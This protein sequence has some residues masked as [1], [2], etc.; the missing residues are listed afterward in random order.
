[1]AAAANRLVTISL[2]AVVLA[3]CGGDGGDRDEPTPPAES[4][5]ASVEPVDVFEDFPVT[6]QD[7]AQLTVAAWAAPDPIRFAELTTADVHGQIIDLPGPPNPDWTFIRCAEDGDGSACSFY[8]ADGDELVL[9]VDHALLGGPR[10]T[11]AARFE[12]TGYPEDVVAYLEAFVTAWQAGNLARMHNLAVAAAV[13]VFVELAPSADAAYEAG[14]TAG[15]LTDVT[16]TLAG[17][18]VSTQVSRALLGEQH[19]I[20]AAVPEPVT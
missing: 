9:T 12:T 11:T 19:A 17:W 4:G 1:V 15:P 5:S 16:V 2:A 13:E 7:Y 14:E 10:A 8:N 18:T 6:P 3:G 20:R